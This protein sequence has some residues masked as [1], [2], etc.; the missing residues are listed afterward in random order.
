MES[1][2]EGARCGRGRRP[3]RRGGFGHGRGGHTQVGSYS[4]RSRGA[5]SNPA[6]RDNRG[7]RQSRGSGRPVQQGSRQGASSAGA[8]NAASLP[9]RHHVGE[10]PLFT[11]V[12]GAERER[13]IERRT[14]V[15][16]FNVMPRLEPFAFPS[17]EEITKGSNGNTTASS[18]IF[19]FAKCAL[20]KH[21]HERLQKAVREKVVASLGHLRV[22]PQKG[23]GRTISVTISDRLRQGAVGTTIALLDMKL[24]SIF[25]GEIVQVETE[26]VVLFHNCEEVLD[27]QPTYAFTMV[28]TQLNASFCVE[29]SSILARRKESSLLRELWLGTSERDGGTR[30]VQCPQSPDVL[31]RSQSEAF[32]AGVSEEVALIHAPS[33]CGAKRL[34]KAMVDYLCLNEQSLSKQPVLLIVQ[35]PLQL[36]VKLRW[37]PDDVFNMNSEQLHEATKTAQQS[38][39]AL[40]TL[41]DIKTTLD[42]LHD[43]LLQMYDAETRI[44]H[45]SSFE[46]ITRAFSLKRN[47]EKNLLEAWILDNVKYTEMKSSVSGAEFQR[48][49]EHCKQRPVQKVDAIEPLN[50]DICFT[51]NRTSQARSGPCQQTYVPSDQN[52]L[53]A[54]YVWKTLTSTIPN[55]DLMSARDIRQLEVSDRWRLYKHWVVLF[56]EMKQRE[57][58]ATLQRLD[59]FTNQYRQVWTEARACLKLSQPVI[60]ASPV[61]AVTHRSLLEVLRPRVTMVCGVTEIEDFYVPTLLPGSAEKVV[62]MADSLNPRQASSCW[63]D[64]LDSKHFKVYDL[65][66]QYFQ[67]QEVCDLLSPFLKSSLVSR[68]PPQRVNGIGETVQFFNIPDTIEAAFMISR[69]CV[70]LQAHNYKSSYV[71]V[72]VLSPRQGAMKA[73]KVALV[74]QGCWY[75]VCTAK[76]FYPR[77]CK[78]ALVYLGPGSLGTQFAAAL[79]RVSFAVYGFGDFSKIDESCQNVLNTAKAR[80]GHLFC[81]RLSL[82][83]VCHPGRVIS[84]ASRQDFEAK[85][86]GDGFCIDPSSGI[87]RCGHAC[88]FVHQEGRQVVALCKHPCGKTICKRNHGCPNKC[89]EPCSRLCTQ[90]ATEKLPMCGHDATLPCHQLDTVLSAQNRLLNSNSSSSTRKQPHVAYKCT[91][92]MT[93]KRL[94]G[95]LVRTRCC[96]SFSHCCR[97]P[98]QKTLPTCGHAATLACYMW[99]DPAKLTVHKCGETVTVRGSCGHDAFVPCHNLNYGMKGDRRLPAGHKCTHGV[100]KNAPCGHLVK[101]KCFESPSGPCQECER[102]CWDHGKEL[103]ELRKQRG[104]QTS[105]SSGMDARCPQNVPSPSRETAAKMLPCGHPVSAEGSTLGRHAGLECQV[106]VPVT[107]QCG[108]VLRLACSVSRRTVK[109]PPCPEMVERPQPCGHKAYRRCAD[110]SWLDG[111][112]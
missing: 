112:L 43:L 85:L 60:L 38:M 73:L 102:A 82:T 27:V 31:D 72:L 20:V 21:T 65:V 88:E 95:H 8:L 104:L 26:Q 1:N 32:C 96:D 13:G 78:I 111:T 79:S 58:R 16:P 100:M 7:S 110:S 24:Q 71:A 98:R 14:E 101:A 105:G 35:N 80:S 64:L 89:S 109:F 77:R 93:K 66:F 74:Q 106:M 49:R 9:T 47:Q 15:N 28:D 69:V 54:V 34:L 41:R 68:K 23:L 87:L 6:R 46:G 18:N 103:A 45:Q 83:C 40:C 94:C 86:H 12:E 50:E 99:D 59:G 84:V 108:H 107:R 97:E 67:S 63:K 37:T 51:F 57:L 3:P 44:L 39:Q 17:F 62:F 19:E 81:G 22:V 42:K 55:A 53:K 91:V 36:Q 70:H 5:A 29:L 10:R 25:Y 4:G 61:I 75:G 48:F 33:G 30:L 56:L 90:L 76:A 92:E 11:G 2:Q 52:A